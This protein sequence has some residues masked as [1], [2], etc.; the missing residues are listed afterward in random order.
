[1]FLLGQLTFGGK[2][3]KFSSYYVFR[4]KLPP[5]YNISF[6]IFCLIMSISSH[7]QCN[8]Y[9]IA[10][11]AH[12]INFNTIFIL[13]NLLHHSSSQSS[14]FYISI[15]FKALCLVWSISLPGI[16]Y[17]TFTWLDK[18][19]KHFLIHYSA[20]TSFSIIVIII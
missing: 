1:M 5:L 13:I 18:F 2:Y 7:K 8:K 12:S 4:F 19:G 11:A 10:Q 15:L 3:W 17:I 6:C 14:Y 16:I 9:R 20:E